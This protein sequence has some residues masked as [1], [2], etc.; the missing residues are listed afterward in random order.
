M[1]S[2]TKPCLSYAPGWP[3]GTQVHSHVWHVYLPLW[4]LAAVVETSWPISQRIGATKHECVLINV[5]GCVSQT[6]LKFQVDKTYKTEMLI[7]A[8]YSPNTAHMHVG[9]P[10]KLM[11]RQLRA[12]TYV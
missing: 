8:K 3:G 4:F 1:I 10:T 6:E 12:R 11:R 7:C 9:T 5:N 2:H